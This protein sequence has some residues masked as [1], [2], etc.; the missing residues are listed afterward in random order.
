MMIKS[1]ELR[2]H[3]FPPLRHTVLLFLHLSTLLWFLSWTMSHSS[4]PSK[5]SLSRFELTGNRSHL[6]QD[7]P[8][9]LPS[10]NCN[11]KFLLFYKHVCTLRK[12]T[13]SWCLLIS[14]L[15]PL[16]SGPSKIVH[17]C[18]AS[19][20]LPQPYFTDTTHLTAPKKSGFFFIFIFF[21]SLTRF[22]W[23]SLVLHL[24]P[25]TFTIWFPPGF[26]QPGLCLLSSLK[27]VSISQVLP[28]K[29]SLLFSH[30]LFH[31]QRSNLLP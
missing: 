2:F 16:S 13:V 7:L 8:S 1:S 3:D 24:P 9:S 31:W 15:Y 21:F 17:I 26:P 27:E 10:L 22:P 12:P 20:S 25:G 4:Y 18:T 23:S 6:L 30:M 19:R 29:F 14:S 11:F 28:L 5:S